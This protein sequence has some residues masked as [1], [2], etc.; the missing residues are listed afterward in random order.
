MSVYKRGNVYYM[1]FVVEGRRVFKSTKQ[2]TKALA[3][4]V[5]RMERQTLEEQLTQRVLLDRIP[6]QEAIQDVYEDR[7]E[8]QRSGEQTY[9]RLLTVCQAVGNPYLD[10][11]TPQFVQQLKRWS[12]KRGHKAATTNRYLAHLKTVL[13]MARDE[14]E[15]VDRVPNISLTQERE[16]V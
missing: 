5:E 7:W 1:D 4:K 13:L 12:K 11:I 10:E 16:R 3:L 15:V 8:G 14:W 9:K 2:K 6:L